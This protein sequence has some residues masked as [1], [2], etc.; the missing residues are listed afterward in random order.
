LLESL[1]RLFAVSALSPELV[2]VA[3]YLLH[4]QHALS[5][6]VG[7]LGIA[8]MRNGIGRDVRIVPA[9]EGLGSV[10]AALDFQFQLGNVIFQ[11]FYVGFHL[12]VGLPVLF[13]LRLEV[14][15]LAVPSGDLRAHL[16]EFAGWQ[17]QQQLAV[18]LS[19]REL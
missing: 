10:A 13:E 18:I 8:H 19:A 4:H 9:G 3:L 15:N 12:L 5:V 1:S 16:V 17:R 7:V 11:L 2:P 6:G 14:L